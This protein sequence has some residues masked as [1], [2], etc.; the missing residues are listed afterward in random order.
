MD[1]VGAARPKRE[2]WDVLGLWQPKTAAL[3]GAG[4]GLAA[5]A[6]AGGAGAADLTVEVSGLRNGE[7]T[8][9]VTV[10]TATE[11]LSPLCGYVGAAP[12]S[13]GVVTVTG[14][15]PGT[16]AVQAIHDENDNRALD[17]P[18]LLPTEGVGFS[19]DAP[20][21]RGPPRFEDAAFALTEAGATV[22]LTMRYFQ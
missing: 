1:Q 19:R 5:L 12:A 7:G 11:F 22:R 14:V 8:I 20:L 6:L 9:L 3:R 16:Y 17:R 15:P 10:C 2:N 21:R 4:A 18:G 13:G